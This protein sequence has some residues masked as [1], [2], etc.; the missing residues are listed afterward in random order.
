M[1][2]QEQKELEINS[3]LVNHN[4]DPFHCR[5]NLACHSTEKN[6][7]SNVI[8]V[9]TDKEGGGGIYTIAKR[10]LVRGEH[11]Q[12]CPAI[13][14]AFDSASIRESR[15]GFCASR[16]P[17]S[18]SDATK[19]KD[20]LCTHC[21][22]VAVCQ[23]CNDSGVMS[24]HER[25]GECQALQSLALCY[26]QLF[27]GG[28][29]NEDAIEIESAYILTVRI[30]RRQWYE[31]CNQ[32]GHDEK[33]NEKK[34]DNLAEAMSS[35]FP[36]V[37]WSLFKHLH[38]TDVSV[39]QDDV[40][41]SQYE[42]AVSALCQ[43][44]CQDFC[45]KEKD[46]NKQ[47][48]HHSNTSDE[49]NTLKVNEGRSDKTSSERWISKSQFE[50]VLGKVMGCCHAITDVSLDLGCQALGRALFLEH[51]FYNHSCVPNAFLSCHIEDKHASK[52]DTEKQTK[53]QQTHNCALIARVHC[54]QDIRRGGSMQLSYIPTSGL[55]RK[56]R[57]ERL[58]HD[59]HF[60]CN[61]VVCERPI[62]R[63]QIGNGD[64]HNKPKVTDETN[65][66]QREQWNK[67]NKALLVPESSDLDVIRQ[68][69]YRCNE[70][71]LDYQK[72]ENETTMALATAK[73]EDNDISLNH[74][75]GMIR[76]SRN[77]IQNQGIGSSHEVSIE[78][79]RLM[80]LAM[81]LSGKFELA[82]DEHQQF[83]NAIEPIKSIFDPVALST[84]RLEFASDLVKVGDISQCMLQLSIAK[85]EASDALG[86]DHSYVLKI[87]DMIKCM[88]V[89]RP[90]KRLKSC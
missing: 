2:K 64:E 79:R 27:H 72:H 58:F 73:T 69:Q 53:N 19:K 6:N 76:M 23:S 38:S 30:L 67:W 47:Y 36:S 60:Q 41:H 65:A 74:S 54:I 84:S 39:G 68:V 7:H 40:T 35:P 28:D 82:N 10:S 3:Y 70:S 31:Q 16:I 63:D 43:L 55:G 4:H 61:C 1:G 78:A 88:N 34:R 29:E 11:I 17:S 12:S 77:G 48:Q 49:H 52:D 42:A 37:D 80:A 33:S 89:D 90:N 14:I 56:E 13:A 20:S 71:L 81:S 45:K 85:K 8:E 25:S 62:S 46:A 32:R 18:E 22:M 21:S 5:S 57:Q 75:I 83:L 26:K 87:V 66:E 9:T 44:I 59:Y 51:S 15:C 24:W 86:C 50:D